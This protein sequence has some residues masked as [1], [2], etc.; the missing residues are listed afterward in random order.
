MFF[1]P[2]CTSDRLSQWYRNV[3]FL[4]LSVTMSE[5]DFDEYGLSE[6]GTKSRCAEVCVSSCVRLRMCATAWCAHETVRRCVL[7]CVSTFVCVCTSACVCS[8]L[9]VSM[10]APELLG[11]KYSTNQHCSSC[12][13]PS[14]LTIR[15]P[16]RL[17]TKT[18]ESKMQI[19]VKIQ[20]RLTYL[21]TC[22]GRRNR[23]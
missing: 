11:L 5:V 14:L 19:P 16:R 23:N 1:Y 4:L 22:L 8:C 10:R 12:Q 15:I 9:C 20:K 6:K 3:L 17:T 21:E 18:G 7:M 2:Q 13:F